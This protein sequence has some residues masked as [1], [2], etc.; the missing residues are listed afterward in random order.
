MFY[1]KAA[2]YE[3]VRSTTDDNKITFVNAA[4]GRN[5]EL[6]MK[7][8]TVNKTVEI[9]FADCNTVVAK[10]ERSYWPSKFVITVT[11]NVDVSL[12]VAICI[13]HY[14]RVAAAAAGSASAPYIPSG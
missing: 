5:V 4:D 3:P 11:P 14:K 7:K 13:C 10:I 12:V 9:R 1:W 2:N 8:G 6:Q